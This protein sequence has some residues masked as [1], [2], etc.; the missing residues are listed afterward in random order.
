MAWTAPARAGRNTPPV[1]RCR[2]SEVLHALLRQ[3]M[4]AAWP[5]RC[6]PRNLSA[7]YPPP[8][9]RA[10]ALKAAACGGWC[11]RQGAPLLTLPLSHAHLL[12]VLQMEVDGGGRFSSL[13]S[14]TSCTEGGYSCRRKASAM[15]SASS[16]AS[17]SFY[18]CRRPFAAFILLA[19]VL[20]HARFKIAT[21]VPFILC[22]FLLK[23]AQLLLANSWW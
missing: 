2:R 5:P 9:A 8:P 15:V 11:Q 16:A 13:A 21:F 18:S 23:I 7:A 19:S 10:A 20:Y 4:G 3:G 6:P 1:R 12:H 22:V 14:P 17:L